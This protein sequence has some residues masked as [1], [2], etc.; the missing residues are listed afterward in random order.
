MA[1]IH[2]IGDYANANPNQNQ[3]GMQRMGGLGGFGGGGADANPETEARTQEFARI[4]LSSTG[5]VKDPRKE[6]VWDM[7]HFN[8]CPKL[9]LYSFISIICMVNLVVYIVELSKDGIDKKGD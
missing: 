6:N 7:F 5:N 1:N 2:R 9:K 3:G 4:L 8:F